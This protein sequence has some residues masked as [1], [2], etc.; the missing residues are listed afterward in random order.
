MPN[1]RILRVTVPHMSC[2]SC[3]ARVERALTGVSGASDITVNL[4]QL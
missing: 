4:S 2:G 1:K 3:A